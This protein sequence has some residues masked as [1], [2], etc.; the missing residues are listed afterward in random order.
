MT[1]Y[2]LKKQINR[3]F[4]GIILG[5]AV[6]EIFISLESAIFWGQYSRCS[7]SRRLSL[8]PFSE[9]HRG[10][11]FG[12]EC[13]HTSA[14]KSVCTFSV[15]MF[16]SYIFLIAVMIK[17]KNEILGRAPLDEGYAPVPSFSPHPSSSSSSSSTSSSIGSDG[18]S[19]Y[20][21]Q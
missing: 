13:Q 1:Y 16:L 4:F 14:M 10:L 3:T 8:L 9:S 21:P 19:T 2:F 6:M 20:V 17:F 18:V 11:S 5:G 15:M 12:V 7:N